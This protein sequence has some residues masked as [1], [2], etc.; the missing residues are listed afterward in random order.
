[1]KNIFLF[2]L[3]C[4]AMFATPT[5]LYSQGG[6]VNSPESPTAIL[7]I[8]GAV[9]GFVVWTRARFRARRKF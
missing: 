7:A 9:G 1:M 3:V 5:A 8:V 2:V 4:A 6:C